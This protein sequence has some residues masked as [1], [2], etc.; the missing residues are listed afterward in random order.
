[1]NW[2]DKSLSCKALVVSVSTL[3]S[4]KLGMLSGWL[5]I[6]LAAMALDYMTGVIGAAYLRQL[7]SRI[8]LRG[9]VRKVANCIVIAVALL[10]DEVIARTA[11][12]GGVSL[13]GMVATVVTIWMILNELISILENLAKMDIALPAFLL[14]LITLLK[15]KVTAEGDAAATQV[16]EPPPPQ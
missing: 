5:E 13:G 7:N 6:Y 9:I 16:E 2:L 15:N 14:R 8:G 10:A 3:L 4:V 11:L 1:M 12:L